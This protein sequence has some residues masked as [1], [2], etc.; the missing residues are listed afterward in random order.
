MSS[1]ADPRFQTENPMTETVTSPWL[2][3]VSIN[4]NQTLGMCPNELS[5]VKTT[6]LVPL[7]RGKGKMEKEVEKPNTH[8]ESSKDIGESCSSSMYS[9]L[10]S[11]TTDESMSIS[12][13][14]HSTSTNEQACDKKPILEVQRPSPSREIGLGGVIPPTKLYFRTIQANLSPEIVLRFQLPVKEI[15]EVL[16][17]DFEALKVLGQVIFLYIF[18][19][20]NIISYFLTSLFLAIGYC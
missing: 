14:T 19:I 5:T 3:Q 18:I 6:S 13:R 20:D 17:T 4:K 9:L 15:S 1:S 8:S 16:V 10:K 11:E 2:E 7:A 12:F